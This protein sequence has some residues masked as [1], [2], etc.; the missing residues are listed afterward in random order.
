[1]GISAVILYN[2]NRVSVYSESAKY[3]GDSF[4][5]GIYK[6][7]TDRNGN[8]TINKIELPE[9]HNPYNTKDNKMIVKTVDA[10]FKKGTREKVN[11]FGYIHKLGILFYGKQ[12]CGKTSMMNFIVEKLIREKKAIVFYC[13]DDNELET[14]IS[15]AKQVRKI[16]EN[17]IV[18]VA[19]EI[20]KY[21]RDFESELKQFLDGKDSVDNSLFLAAT[22]YLDRVPETIKQRPSRFKIVHEMKGITDKNFIKS[23]LRE[24]SNRSTPSL[25]SEEKIEEIANEL[26]EPTIDDIKQ[27]C[28]DHITENFIPKEIKKSVIGFR[29]PSVSNEANDE[30]EEDENFKFS[31]IKF[32]GGESEARNEVQSDIDTSI[33]TNIE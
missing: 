6:C 20:D 11:S 19:D 10:F 27:I 24:I 2:D 1:M 3:V 21:C 29:A 28:I 18:F 15:L 13:D 17:P 16:Q 30:D 22:N 9:I 26:D 25:L 33:H 23:I 31:I 32:L 12:G 7:S 14:S 8:I 4:Q 5:K